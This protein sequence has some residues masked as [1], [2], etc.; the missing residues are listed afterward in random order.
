MR[1]DVDGEGWATA[2]VEFRRDV[3]GR[4]HHGFP[5]SLL[6]LGGMLL[7]DLALLTLCLR[8]VGVTATEV[9]VAEIAVAYLFAYPFT[10]FPF[11]G[12]GV[13]DALVLAALVEVGGDPVEAPSVA[14]LVVWR[15]FTV[16][17]PVLL[18]LVALGAWRHERR[19]VRPGP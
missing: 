13:V 4:F 1:R 15:V 10:L 14:A 5:R 18:G 2:C 8:F 11:S 19:A 17:G 7:A 12:I 3:A 16:A 6:A 9:A